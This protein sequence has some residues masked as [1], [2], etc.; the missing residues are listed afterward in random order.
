MSIQINTPRAQVLLLDAPGPGAERLAAALR[1][2]GH[3][4]MLVHAAPEALARISAGEVDLVL[5]ELSVGGAE[6]LDDLPED[7]PPLVLLDT[8]GTAEDARAHA[9]AGAAEVLARPLPDELLVERIAAQLVRARERREHQQLG[10]FRFGDLTSRDQRMAAVFELAERVADT[11]TGLLFRGESGTGK[12]HL[13]RAVH[14][15]SARADAPFVEVNCGAVPGELLVSELFGHVKG[16]FTGAD[17]D[18]VG[19]FEAAHGGTIFLD[20]IAS[21]SLDMQVK[22][23]RVLESQRFERVGDNRTI[24]V[25]V[26]VLA[27]CNEDLES[28]VA[29]GTFRE[30]LFWRLN[31]VPIVIPPLRERPVDLLELG[32]RFATDLAER[33]GRPASLARLDPAVQAVLLAH[34]WP[35][36]V[37]EL[38]HRLERAVLLARGP[39]LDPT[40]FGELFT[41]ATGTPTLV[42][43]TGLPPELVAWAAAPPGP[44]K[45]G[46]ALPERLLV[47][48]ALAATDGCRSDAAAILDINRS[49][50]FNK[51]RRHGLL[52]PPAP[53][54]QPPKVTPRIESPE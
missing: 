26:R 23:L 43:A 51:M 14:V 28:A 15:A 46:L 50:L 2:G 12:T 21:A 37:R 13:A 3:E 22:L 6:L 52:G 27:A 24:E 4:L 31:V 54:Q 42:A 45:A 47:Q 8:F 20:E 39:L 7:G 44:L 53:S 10:C 30:D 19:K 35:G 34:D 5:A 16:S 25:D 49:T 18:R 17:R 41:D 29:A 1:T 38:Q 33:H 48:R 32:G 36:N 9:L 11:R 40:D